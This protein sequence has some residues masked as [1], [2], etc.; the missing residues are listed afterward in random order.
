MLFYHCHTI[1]ELSIKSQVAVDCPGLNH[2]EGC[3]L[4]VSYGHA[5][6]PAVA[7]ITTVDC[8]LINRTPKMVR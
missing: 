3:R 8:P 5:F 4:E 1:Y 7:D 2:T 6:A